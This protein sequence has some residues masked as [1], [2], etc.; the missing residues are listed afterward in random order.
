MLVVI[1]ILLFLILV[2]IAPEMV[3]TLI[4][5]A[6]ILGALAIGTVFLMIVLN[7]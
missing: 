6:V 7:S 2:A 3:A 5:W 1:A 4:G